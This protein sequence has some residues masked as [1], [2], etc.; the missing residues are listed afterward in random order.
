MNGK[1]MTTLVVLIAFAALT[2]VAVYHHG[3]VGIVTSVL[4][5]TATLQ[6][7]VDLVIALGFVLIWMW[8][9]AKERGIAVWPYVLVTLLAGS[10][11]PLLYFV[12]RLGHSAPVVSRSAEAG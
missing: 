4:V 11:G 1:Q 2:A 3:Y 5:S 6:V 9:D 12:R 8:Q 10:F 7:L